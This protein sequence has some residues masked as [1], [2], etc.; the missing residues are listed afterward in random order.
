MITS[1]TN[2]QIKNIIQLRDK[3]KARNE[4]DSYLVEGIKMF[5]ELP[6]DE[7]IKVYASTT[8]INIEENQEMLKDIP[9]EEV[10]DNIFKN[11]SDTVSP[12]GIMAIAR[13]KHYDLEE[14]LEAKAKEKKVFL[15]LESLRDPGNLGTIIRTGE[16]AGISGLILNKDSVDIYNPK[17]IRSTMGSIFR[18]P[19]FYTND[20]SGTIQKMKEKEIKIFAAHLEGENI[21]ETREDYKNAG[22]IIGNESSGISEE[23]KNTS[24]KLIKIPM[25]GQV[26]SLNAGVSAAILIYEFLH[27]C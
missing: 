27:K 25:S 2:P 12:Q 26:E 16:A 15:I 17:V 5:R 18:L 20:L 1:A 21:F 13:Q 9:Y 22:I 6:A 19:F 8:F 4:Q 3:S 23:I 7:I 11:L 10:S 14:M 24:D